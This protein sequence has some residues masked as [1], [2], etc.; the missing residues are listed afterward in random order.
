MSF[1]QPVNETMELFIEKLSNT[2]KIN[3]DELY[4]LWNKQDIK[5]STQTCAYL[6]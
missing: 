2:Y 3:K 1:S 6:G 4:Q 5:S